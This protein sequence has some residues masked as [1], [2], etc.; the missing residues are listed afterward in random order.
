[1]LICWV[2]PRVV[3]LIWYLVYVI[4]DLHPGQGMKIEKSLRPNTVSQHNVIIL[5]LTTLG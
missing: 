3:T 1:M 4:G 2:Q 5:V